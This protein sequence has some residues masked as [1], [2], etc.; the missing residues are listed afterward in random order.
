MGIFSWF[1]R[2][3]REEIQLS[4]EELKWNK[5]WELWENEEVESPYFELMT[6]YSEVN[7]GGH[8]QFWDYVSDNGDLSTYLN[9]LYKI[10]PDELKENINKSYK[11]YLEMCEVEYSEAADE[12]LMKC[13]EV[14]AEN[15][16]VIENIL[17][18]YANSIVL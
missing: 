12:V 2:K 10:M 16:N 4:E 13:D 11:A 8:G 18:E 6:Y 3:K 9:S 17:K 15:E 14:F 5:M 7:N 1:K